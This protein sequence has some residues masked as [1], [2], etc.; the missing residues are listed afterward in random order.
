MTTSQTT[1]DP[2]PA[3]ELP[4]V[5][6]HPLD[7][8]PE[9]GALREQ[10]PL[11]RLRYPD[12]HIGWLAT[13]YELA[14]ALLVDP[15]FSVRRTRDPVGDPDVVTAL[16]EAVYALPE[17]GGIIILLDPPEHTR[18]R[19]ELAGFFTVAGVGGY[20]GAIE[21]ALSEAIEEMKAIGPPVDFVD[22]F[23]LPVSCMTICKMLGAPG[24]DREEFVRP[25]AVLASSTSTVEDKVAALTAFLDYC[26][27]LIAEKRVRPA[28][29]LLSH[30]VARGELTDDEIAGVALQLLSAGHDT[31]ATMLGLG[32][33][34]L[35]CDRSRWERLRERP[36]EIDGAVEQL[37]R[38]LTILQAGAFTRTACE[39]VEIDGVVI[40]AGESVTVSLA[41]ANR[42]PDKF[43]TPDELDL[44]GGASGHLA[45]GHGRHMCLGQHLA[46]L[47][48]KLSFGALMIDFPNLDL[49]VG[50]DQVSFHDGEDLLFG[51][52]ELPVVW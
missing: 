19:R 43:D 49:A 48:L 23:A 9:L 10:R 38:Y 16:Y 12:G 45:F 15:R 4:T 7:P 46:R 36:T 6:N 11:C 42:D 51:V 31:T 41:A 18:V 26:R 30:L 8:A 25:N 32:T 40:R 37:L 24:E 28:D 35:L 14:R 13:S 22:V 39:D 33:F 1:I 44:S 3:V 47:E 2:G 29:D 27:E 34:A 17:H 20:R 52:R 5:R 50:G 21:G